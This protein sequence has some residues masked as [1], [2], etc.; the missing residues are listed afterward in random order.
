LACG[1]LPPTAP[2]GAKDM[3]PMKTSDIDLTSEQ[4]ALVNSLCEH[5]LRPTVVSGEDVF[6]ACTK[7]PATAS[8]PTTSRKSHIQWDRET[9]PS[10]TLVRVLVA[11]DPDGGCD[12]SPEDWGD[13]DDSCVITSARI[14]QHYG[15]GK[16]GEKCA[17]A[18]SFDQIQKVDDKDWTAENV[19]AL[20][21]LIDWLDRLDDQTDCTYLSSFQ[22]QVLKIGD[23]SP[24]LGARSWKYLQS[25][26]REAA[27]E[28][29]CPGRRR[30]Q[31]ARR[32][33]GGLP[34]RAAE[35]H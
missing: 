7:C 14:Q 24:M 4:E 21:D 22:E 27:V 26:I 19:Q 34:R 17:E 29:G 33:Q 9:T 8:R 5:D 18:P 1:A 12:D 25:L 15:I 23:F 2:T 30:P 32:S 31:Y 11:H 6:L 10:L 20:I 3:S 28:G 13:L 35:S 16:S